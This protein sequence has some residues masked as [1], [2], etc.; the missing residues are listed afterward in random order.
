[1]ASRRRFVAAGGSAV[2]A[3]ALLAIPAGCRGKFYPGTVV[4]GD[5]DVG[6]MTRDQAEALV[7]VRIA[8]FRTA[9]V[10]F[11]HDDRTWIASLD[12]LGARI[13]TRTLLDR[14]AQRGRDGGLIGRYTTWF[15]GHE[16]GERIPA[17]VSIDDDM[18]IAYLRGI[19][20]VVDVAPANAGL[21]R[22]GTDL[23]IEEGR[24]GV[25]VDIDAAAP[26]PLP[27]GPLAA[28][29]DRSP[30]RAD[31]PGHYRQRPRTV[32]ETGRRPDRRSG[33]RRG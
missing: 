21:V 25:A 2:I 7:S 18:L 6:G 20:A 4:L 19:A 8:S 9:A 30:H 11:R 33:H 1:M 5:L 12:D 26:D 14:A 17:P 31:R 15:S 22:D 32:P 28:S 16:P 24:A 13:D 23:R 3:T 29:D 27:A 10:T